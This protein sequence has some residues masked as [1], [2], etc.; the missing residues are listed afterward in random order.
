MKPLSKAQIK[1]LAKA[2]S[3]PSGC[4]CPIVGVHAAAETALLA[5][6]SRRGLIIDGPAP[7]ISDAGRAAIQNRN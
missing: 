3:R 4:L 6:L 1:A 5:A 2:A 7:R